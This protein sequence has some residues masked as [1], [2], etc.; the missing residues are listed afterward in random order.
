MI[1]GPDMQKLEQYAKAVMADLR[2]VPGAVDVD[3]SLSTGKPQYG[4]RVDRPKAAELGVSIA[5]I[6]NTLRL[7]VAGDKVSDYTDR[8]EQYEVHVRCDRRRAQPAR[9][10]ED[11]HRAVEQVRHGPL[12]RRGSLR[13]GDRSRPDQPPRPHPAGHDQ[14]QHDAR[15]VATDV[16]GR[17]RTGPPRT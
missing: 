1:G 3:S 14:R 13:E 2:K 5:D 11:D 9:R 4:I 7:L 16:V 15:H 12:G 17:D 8:G 10:I 6:A